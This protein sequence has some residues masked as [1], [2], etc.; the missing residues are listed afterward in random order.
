ML[1]QDPST[2]SSTPQILGEENK[3]N[4]EESLTCFPS[5]VGY[6][7]RGVT[8]EEVDDSNENRS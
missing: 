5:S 1:P 3:I 6:S 2:N 8:G 7:K 4:E